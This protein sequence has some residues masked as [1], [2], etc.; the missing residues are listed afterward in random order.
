[1]ESAPKAPPAKPAPAPGLSSKLVAFYGTLFPPGSP[2][3][4][5]GPVILAA[6]L[7]LFFLLGKCAFSSLVSK[8][9]EE[10]KAA[11]AVIEA[12]TT[13]RLVV[14]SNRANTTI[15]ATRVPAAGEVASPGVSGSA[16]GASNQTL[17]GLPAGKY[18]LTAR[19]EGWPDIRQEVSVTVGGTAE[20]AVNF[21]SGSLRLDSDPTGATV[22]FGQ[23]VLGQT[24]LVIP[25]LPPGECPLTLEY[26][27]WPVLTFKATIAENVESTETARLPHG[28]LVVESTPPGATVVLD[29]RK[30][31]QTPLTL[32][33]IPAGAKKLTLQAKDFPTL[34]VSGTVEDRGEMKVNVPL[35]SGYPEL[36][37]PALLRAVWVSDNPDKLSPQFDT[38]GPF[39]PQNGIVKNLLRKRLYEL[40]LRRSF[41]FSATVKSYDPASGQ[42]EFD[43]Q[44]SELSR[45]RVLAK[46]SPEARGNKDLAAQLAKG[47]TFELYGRLSAVEEPRWPS[48]VITFVFSSAEPLH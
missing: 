8:S 26:P 24:P 17:P 38:A 12:K 36:D 29:G 5:F 3:R 10:V 2:Q 39:Q 16:E 18:V 19:S 9:P 20:A 31:G 1:V 22:R 37:P 21:K 43:E 47:A 28:K 4:R 15:E 44:K 13:G 41:R 48:K 32:E 6:A 35:G 34:T 42:I 25:Q 11:Q 33:N 7:V 23:T 40:W 14:K 46:L 45:Y 30:I 27:S